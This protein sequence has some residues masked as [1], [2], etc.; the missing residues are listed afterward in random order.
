MILL[1]CCCASSAEEPESESNL[2]FPDQGD[3][4]AKMDIYTSNT[5][6]SSKHPVLFFI[7]GGAWCEG[8]KSML[9]AKQCDFFIEHGFV[10]VSSN[11]TLTPNNV[12]QNFSAQPTLRRALNDLAHNLKWVRDNI[13]RYNGDGDKIYLMVHSAGAHLAAMLAIAPQY[14]RQAG[15]DRKNICSVCCLDGGPYMGP[16]DLLNDPGLEI[17]KACWINAIGSSQPEKW[18]SYIPGQFIEKDATYPPFLLI[19]SSK[20]AHRYIPNQALATKLSTAQCLVEQYQY[21][22]EHNDFLMNLGATDQLQFNKQIVVFGLNHSR[23]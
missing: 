1:L 22:W 19:Y 9:T 5:L 3:V 12:H 11:Y 18:Q 6:S 7:H 14:C 8:D 4:T 10:V 2:A 23:N 13:S 20:T 21:P 15:I 16:I 17:I